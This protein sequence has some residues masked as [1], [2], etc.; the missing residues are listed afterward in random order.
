MKKSGPSFKFR[1]QRY[2]HDGTV[3]HETR[4]GRQIKMQRLYTR[5]PGCGIGFRILTTATAIRTRNL[6]RRCD[7]CKRQGVP[8]EYR[9]PPKTRRKRPEGAAK[10][11]PR[12]GRLKSS[13]ST[14]APRFAWWQMRSILRW[15]AE[16]KAS[17]SAL[18]DA[19]KQGAVIAMGIGKPQ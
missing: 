13:A 18:V 17:G 2:W 11:N 10:G 6:R 1:S 15:P 16:S 5:C 4:D 12:P 14:T 9:L 3:D 7:G 8:V 19:V